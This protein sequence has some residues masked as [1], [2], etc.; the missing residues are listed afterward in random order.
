MM[1]KRLVAFG[2]AGVMLMGMSMNV[3]AADGDPDLNAGNLSGQTSITYTVEPTY[4]ITIPASITYSKGGSNLITFTTKDILL[5]EK[6]E[7][8]IQ[9]P[10]TSVDLN[11]EGSSNNGKYVVSFEDSSDQPITDETK[12]VTFSNADHSNKTIKLVGSAEPGAAGVYKNTVTFTLEYN[13]NSTP[14]S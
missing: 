13:K 8:N 2:L 3:F 4:T 11:L 6:G 10:G 1:K 14:A 9:A 12:I 5:S 7:L